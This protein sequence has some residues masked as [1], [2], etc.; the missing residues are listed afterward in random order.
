MEELSILEAQQQMQTG[1]LSSE[2]LTGFYL[3]RIKRFD[4]ELHS[5]IEVNPEAL[6]IA[7]ALD[8]ERQAGHVRGALHGIPVLLKDNIST[9]QMQTTA[10]SLALEGHVATDDA[11]LVKLLKQAGAVILGKTNM[12]EWANFMTTGMTNGYSSRGGQTIN[13]YDAN[14]TTGGSS[15]GSGVAIAANFAM[16]A[17]GTETSGSILS[18]SNQNNL[19]GIKPTVGLISRNRIVPISSTQDTAGPMA[20]TVMDAALLLEV[21]AGHD[22]SD[23]ITLTAPK[24][25]AYSQLERL[26]L[27]GLRL[28]IP[29]EVFWDFPSAAEKP[30]LEAALE[31]LKKLGA[32]LVEANLPEAKTIADQGYAVLVQEFRR[33]LNKFLRTTKLKN[34]NTLIK[35]N[36]AN[37]EQLLKFGQVLLN[38]AAGAVGT[39]GLE[40]AMARAAD[41]KYAKGGLDAAFEQHNV[42]ALVFPMYWGAKPGAKAGYPTVIVP[43]G[44]T[45]AGHPVGISFLGKA[46]S[47]KTLLEIAFAFEQA[48]KH[49]KAPSLK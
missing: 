36:D 47:E 7:K 11:T 39:N 24:K 30:V 23:P 26:D 42:D 2:V 16:V 13:P 18:P 14:I 29:K 1:S 19:V 4:S 32:T 22:K 3:K 34:L 28:G 37:P 40:Y 21:L 15:S 17:V 35:T 38:A 33:D 48:T 6:N 8:L 46:F 10:G 5:V 27:Q 41:L 12:T 43:A 31:V 44:F 45:E 25:V 49:R 9:A 20:R